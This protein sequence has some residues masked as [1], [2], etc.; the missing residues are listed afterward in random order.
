MSI[1]A[2]QSVISVMRSRSQR[3][4]AIK[5]LE[6]R[7]RRRGHAPRAAAE[8]FAPQSQKSPRA[9]WRAS[10]PFPNL[11]IQSLENQRFSRQQR[12]SVSPS[13]S[14]RIQRTLGLDL[15]SIAPELFTSN[16]RFRSFFSMPH[17][18]NRSRSGRVWPDSWTILEATARPAP[19]SSVRDGVCCG[20][21]GTTS[22]GP[23]LCEGR[24]RRSPCSW[25]STPEPG[26]GGLR[27]RALLT[28]R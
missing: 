23:S 15:L 4:S 22:A 3:E 10:S 1:H 19:G 6:P 26:P 7:K 2:R 21:G 8:R 27:P 14:S 5:S 9:E 16:R 24:F 13:S 28:S 17:V 18:L 20:V 25:I 12:S 11:A